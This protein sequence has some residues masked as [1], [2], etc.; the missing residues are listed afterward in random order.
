PARGARRAGAA[1]ALL[2]VAVLLVTPPVSLLVR[3]LREDGRWSLHAY[4]QMGTE[5]AGMR[6][7]DAASVSVR[8]ALDAALLA[9]AL[10]LL[11]AVALARCRGRG[12]EIADGFMM[13]PLGVSAVTV[14]FGLLITMGL[15]PGDLRRSQ[16][17]VAIAQAMIAMPL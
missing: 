8:T 1:G 9:P 2:M 16:L 10:G 13:L 14:G 17:L 7:L 3:S 6:P 12:K 11:A 15:L 5:V 4:R